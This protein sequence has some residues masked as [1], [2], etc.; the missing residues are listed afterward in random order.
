MFIV[1]IGVKTTN[2]MRCLH[3]QAKQCTKAMAQSSSQTMQPERNCVDQPH[4][5]KRGSQRDV[6]RSHDGKRGSQQ[7]WLKIMFRDQHMQQ[8]NHRAGSETYW[9]PNMASKNSS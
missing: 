7:L 6:A 5:S 4:D 8:A 3:S 1:V 2:V 9:V